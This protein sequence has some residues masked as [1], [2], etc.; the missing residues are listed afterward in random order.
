[1][2][3]HLHSPVRQHAKVL[4]LAL[5]VGVLCGAASALF[6]WLLE[7]ATD[8]RV[9]HRAWVYALPLAGLAIGFGYDRFGRAVQAGNNLV[10]DRVVEGGPQVPTRMAPLVMVGTIL[11]H[12]FGGSAGREG[13]AVQMG[14]SL[15]D[16]V[17]HGLRVSSE[18]RQLL[19]MAGMAGGFGSVFGT[20]WAGALFGIEVAVIGR[21]QLR[22]ALPALVASFVGD[23][24]TRALGV[25]HAVYPQLSS[26]TLDLKLAGKWVLFS[27]ALALAT[28]TFIELTHAIKTSSARV[29]PPLPLRMFV[30]GVLVVGM[31]TVTGGDDYLG[32]GVPTILRAFSDPTLAAEAFALKLVFTAVTI[33]FGFIGGEVTPLFF[34]G[35]ALG[36]VMARTLDV[37]LAL[38]ATVGL[39]AVFGSAANTP[40]ALSVMAAELVGVHALPHALLV[41]ALTFLLTG[42]RGIYTA[43][44]VARSKIGRPLSV[45]VALRDWSQKRHS[46]PIPTCGPA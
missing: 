24:V 29:L 35:A 15:A 20:P 23:F 17:S 34:V 43:Q 13:T 38:G 40:L 9:A 41:C 10:L 30:G 31:W 19:L 18:A 45:P 33:G 6:L 1:M 46:K 7:E 32:L 27:I 14:A 16:W 21:L 26:V 22:A 25:G 44:R 36:S 37:P 12:L 11:T 5:P 2:T 8:F 4:L 28:V 42:H 3:T 39:A